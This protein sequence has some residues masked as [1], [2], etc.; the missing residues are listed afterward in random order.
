MEPAILQLVLAAVLLLVHVVAIVVATRASME[1]AWAVGPRDEP[2]QDGRMLGRFKRILANY[3]ETL[4]AFALV[5]LAAELSGR[6]NEWTLA[7][8]WVWLAGRV[9]YLPVYAAG[10]PWVRTIVWIVATLGIVAMLVG[11]ALG[12]A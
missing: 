12:P 1:R 7:G 2:R 10:I 6:G 4:P 3:L 9:V 11:L 8:G 5:L